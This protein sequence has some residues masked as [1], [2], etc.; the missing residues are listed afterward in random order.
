MAFSKIALN[1]RQLRA[2]KR[3]AVALPPPPASI[4][5][6]ERDAWVLDAH[7]RV[8]QW[9]FAAA[10][11]AAGAV[12]GGCGVVAGWRLS[13]PATADSA[14]TLTAVH[15]SVQPAPQAAPVLRPPRP[16]S[17]PGVG[18]S[19]PAQSPASSPA[20][21]LPAPFLPPVPIVRAAPQHVEPHHA[22]VEHA[23]PRKRMPVAAP[24]AQRIVTTEKPV[25]PSAGVLYR[26]APSVP[27]VDQRRAPP[28]PP[29]K[30][31]AAHPFQIVSIPLPG[32]VMVM[33]DNQVV[34]VKVGGK[35]PDGS[36][37]VSADMATGQVRT[38][39]STYQ[40]K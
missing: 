13:Q 36:S 29:A 4:A 40:V 34:P 39:R 35:L 33:R 22:S 1:V 25:T 12:I 15:A 18:A 16:A 9:Q 7:V 24:V 2:P 38:T 28:A 20:V 27:L 6:I 8:R 3:C 11:L 30:A 14:R 37:L 5:D 32:L 19:S 21:A 17:S 23:S 31:A 10:G 26:A